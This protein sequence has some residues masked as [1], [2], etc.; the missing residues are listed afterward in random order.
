[1]TQAYQLDAQHAD[2]DLVDEPSAIGQNQRCRH[3]PVVV[4]TTLCAGRAI[5]RHG[6]R[7]LDTS[8]FDST[9]ESGEMQA[10]MG[11]LINAN[12]IRQLRN[13]VHRSLG[14][15]ARS[16]QSCGGSVY[17]YRTVPDPDD[18]KHKVWAID[19]DEAKIVRRIFDMIE[20]G[21]GYRAICH[22]LNADGIAAPRS[23]AWSHQT[24][25]EM[26]RNE[27]YVGRLIWNR[28]KNTKVHGETITGTRS[29]PSPNTSCATRRR[30]SRPSNSSGYSVS[31]RR[32]R[33]VRCPRRA[34]ARSSR[35]RAACSTAAVAAR[36]TPC[37]VASCAVDA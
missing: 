4:P 16:G 28:T 13:A 30:S 34:R 15:R 36:A 5:G 35:S 3:E 17:G 33:D 24:I 18:A 2:Q 7:L 22:A 37:A 9:S 1:M 8:G 20:A 27:R 31:S 21:T 19:E 23:T 25:M 6:V 32:A 14:E 29:D 11:S 26:V 12:Y 10:V